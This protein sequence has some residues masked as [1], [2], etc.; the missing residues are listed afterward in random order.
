MKRTLVVAALAL[1]A[2]LARPWPA[3]ADVTFFLGTNPT[4]DYRMTRGIS[5]GINMLVVGF[6]FDYSYT[7]GNEEAGIP[8]LQTGM[9]NVLVMTPTKTQVYFTA[10]AGGFREAT[11][12]V[13]E[14]NWGT[15]L[16]GGV[17]FSILGPLQLRLDYRV[18]ALRGEVRYKNPQ[19]FYAGVTIPF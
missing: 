15:N 1:T 4:P 10:G 11:G 17:K 19:R 14:T 16:G 7:N 8:K 6:E 5:A 9:M 13:S 2:L 12:T 18:F 3:A